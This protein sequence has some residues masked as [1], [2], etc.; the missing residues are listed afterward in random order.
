MEAT[1]L[2]KGNLAESGGEI[3]IVRSVGN[4][5]AF[6]K[7]TTT[8]RILTEDIKPIP[9]T[10]EWLLKFGLEYMEGWDD[11][12]Y[13]CCPKHQQFQ[14]MQCIYGYEYDYTVLKYVH[15]LQNLYYSLTGTELSLAKNKTETNNSIE[16]KS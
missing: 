10:E 15:Q 4:S 11:Q 7:K 6:K 13:Y 8:V 14:I 3:G 12:T 9:L 2:R 5:C 1:E 16:T